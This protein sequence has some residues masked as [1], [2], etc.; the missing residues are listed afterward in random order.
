M[1]RMLSKPIFAF[2]SVTSAPGYLPVSAPESLSFI[3][4]HP[5][6]YL[7]LYM[8]V[9]KSIPSYAFAKILY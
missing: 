8:G 6:S 5:L 3:F 1:F 4:L 7:R 9:P 2:I